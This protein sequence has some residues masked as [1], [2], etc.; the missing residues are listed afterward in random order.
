[1]E[2]YTGRLKSERYKGFKL[3]FFKNHS[4]YFNVHGINVICQVYDS[5]GKPTSIEGRGK[6]KEQAMQDAKNGIDF[7]TR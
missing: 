4:R 5:E 7:E 1:M 2:P 6:T 3:K